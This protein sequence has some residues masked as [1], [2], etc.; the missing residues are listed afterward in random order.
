MVKGKI[1]AYLL[2]GLRFPLAFQVLNTEEIGLQLHSPSQHHV[3]QGGLRFRSRE[4][5][6][7]LFYDALNPPWCLAGW[8]AM[9]SGFFCF[10]FSQTAI[11]E[12]VFP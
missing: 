1:K 8:Q 2:L 6:I 3:P 9:R 4:P 11:K 7:Y 5:P 10:F 12:L